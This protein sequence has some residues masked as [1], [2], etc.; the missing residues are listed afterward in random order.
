LNR[1]V[2]KRVA[3]SAPDNRVPKRR[4]AN[5]NHDRKSRPFADEE[6]VLTT[7]ELKGVAVLVTKPR[8][9]LDDGQLV[10][11]FQAR[12]QRNQVTRLP[13]W[14]P[15]SVLQDQPNDQSL[16]LADDGHRRLH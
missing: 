3:P 16:R 14:R 12:E 6:Q 2:L 13:A 5:G 8:R 11:L 4:V 15:W 7:T 10:G 1:A 9:G